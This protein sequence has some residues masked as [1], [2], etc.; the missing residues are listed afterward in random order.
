MY[1]YSSPF[2]L[3]YDSKK[4]KGKNIYNVTSVYEAQP[5]DEE[6]MGDNKEWLL[7]PK[8]FAMKIIMSKKET[9][10]EKMLQNVKKKYHI[11]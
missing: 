5:Y 10:L 7:L 4:R 1:I 11:Y 2:C 9:G 6:N 3:E 8:P